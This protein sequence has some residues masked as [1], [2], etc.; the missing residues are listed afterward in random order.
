MEDC[1]L[2]RQYR[3]MKNKDVSQSSGFS[4]ARARCVR[5]HACDMVGDM[6]GVWA[7]GLF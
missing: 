1:V 5:L 7:G 3:N 4:F 6:V 2:H